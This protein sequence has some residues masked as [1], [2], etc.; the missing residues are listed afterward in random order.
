L[1]SL[2]I[3]IDL[4]TTA[5]KAMV[6]DGS[7]RE[8]SIGSS[9]C[10]IHQPR[11][12]WQEQRVEEVWESMVSA[13]RLAVQDLD[14]GRIEAVA[15]SAAMH[16]FMVVDRDGRPVTGMLTWADGRA[17]GHAGRLAGDHDGSAVFRRTG[18]PAAALY[19]PARILW[20]R[21]HRPDVINGA[22][23]FVSIKEFIVRRLVGKWVTDRSHA[24]SN[25]LLDTRSLSWDEPLLSALGID[26]EQLPELVDSDQ[27][28]GEL[29]EDGAKEMGL[30]G[31][32][33]VVAGAGDGG[34]ANLGA[35]AIDPGQAVV[36]I[37]AS[38]A[39]RKILS[40]PWLDPEERMWLYHL[41]PG[42][43]YAGGA[44]NSGGIV[45]RW[46]R[47]GLLSDERDRA[48]DRGQEP[49]E[50]IIGMADAAGPG[51]EGLM[52]LP[53]LHGERTP[54]WNPSARGVMFGLAPHHGKAHVARAVLEGI[55][56][57]M[58]HVHELLKASP[59]GVAGI[60]ATGGFTRSATWVQLIADVLG[61]AVS[62]P[63]V[64]ESSAMGAAILGMKAAGVI[65]SLSEARE[66]IKADRVFE[67]DPEKSRIHKERFELFKE[68][69]E[70]LAEDFEK[71][72]DMQEMSRD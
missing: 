29:M 2:F 53:F 52:F 64:S 28:A 13:V 69:Y 14:A 41:A 31:G 36:T 24:S 57:S 63:K 1:D 47:D 60:R 65:K 49:Y 45:L 55:C 54:Y 22:G 44:V 35:G 26:A 11:P 17:G 25:G 3:G 9:D 30:P 61:Q 62:L 72:A 37:G 12:S 66:M 68:L 51:A 16:G 4:G 43:W 21:E 18:C 34:L 23:K 59:G 58:A 38:G 39:A 19:Y 71:I 40:E 70:H 50:R 5:V 8:V 42:L 6:V 32:I 20:H 27:V 7:G 56:M 33:P 67:P 10:R 48:L 46:L 15:F